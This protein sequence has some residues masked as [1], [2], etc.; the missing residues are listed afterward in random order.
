[1]HD[2]DD[3]DDDELTRLVKVA[4]RRLPTQGG[5]ITAGPLVATITSVP[6]ERGRDEGW[7]RTWWCG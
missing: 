5:V 6:V 7:V 4:M 2:D 3:D 1:M